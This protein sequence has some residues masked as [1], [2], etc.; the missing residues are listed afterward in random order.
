M[1]SWSFWHWLLGSPRINI[2]WSNPFNRIR[3]WKNSF[4]TCTHC[5]KLWNSCY[6][7]ACRSGTMNLCKRCSIKSLQKYFDYQKQHPEEQ[8]IVQKLRSMQ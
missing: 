1:W 5:N 2:S 4:Y 8:N 3:V 7:G 6:A